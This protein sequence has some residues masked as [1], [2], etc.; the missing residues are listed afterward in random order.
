VPVLYG[1]CDENEVTPFG[2]WAELLSRPFEAIPDDE[3]EAIVDGYGS[4]L[5]R[6]IPELRLRLPTPDSEMHGDPEDERRQLFAAVATLIERLAA[7]R[8]LLLL[9]DDLHWADRSSLLLLRQIAGGESLE[10][11]LIVGTYRDTELPD[12]HPLVELLADLERDR[13]AIRLHLLG[14]GPS[15]LA[16][17]VATW[18]GSELPAKTIEALQRDTGGNPFFITQLVRDL[19]ELPEDFSRVTVPAGLRDVIVKRVAR[20]PAEADRVLKIAALVGREFDLD[21]L[22]AVAGL[23]EEQLLDVLDAAVQAGLL[24]EIEESPGRYSFA[25]ALLRTTL[26]RELTAT[27]SARLHAAIGSA[28]EEAHADDLD[29]HVDE[30]ARHF[31]AAGPGEA[32]R[33]VAYSVRAS[34][35]AAGRLAYDEAASYVATALALRERSPH[36]DWREIA[37]LRLRFGVATSCTGRWEEARTIFAT[38]ADASREADAEYLFARAALGH[39]GGNFERYGLP[40]RASADLLEEALRRLPSEDTPLRAQ[41]LA[42]LGAVLYYLHAPVEAQHALSR[43][44][45]DMARRLDDVESLARALV[46]AQYAYWHPG[47][48]ATR[49]ELAHQLIATSERLGDSYLE[50]GSRIWRAIALLDHC[51]L[52]EAD[53]DLERFGEIATELQRPELLVYAAA[54]RAMRALLEGRWLEG[55]LAAAEVLGLGE[56]TVT[57]NALQSYGVEMMQLRNEQLR[58]GELT[59]HFRRLVDTISALPA[60][61]SA[62][63]WA[64]VQGGRLEQAGNEID[65]LRRDDF[66]LLPR[67]ANL[68]P[69]CAILGHVA[70]ELGDSDLAEAVEPLLRP[71]APY[72]VVMGYGP[73]TLGPVAFT[74]GLACQLTGRLDQAV[75]D[76]ELALALSE[77]MRAR[78]YLAHTRIHL[79]QVLEQRRAP[80]DVVRARG[81]REEGLVTAREL[82]MTRLLRDAGRPVAAVAAPAER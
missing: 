57:P 74:L 34:E 52:D 40:D 50:S 21:L 9:L 61:R 48:Q 1:R 62:L 37:E 14:L 41:V 80:G 7:H 69:A 59:D 72:W 46:A 29:R 78:P 2:L 17:L 44:A 45:L 49:L 18:H 20:L 32:D 3:L 12:S 25:H 19:E 13:P 11:V 68:V 35:I 51:R 38:A 79:A 71:S 77:R 67:D 75:E 36:R 60:W 70:G 42:R 30:L 39:S 22:F 5:A 81:L 15:D 28:I 73:A 56:H 64:L 8:P 23:P 24:L 54:H 53:R 10:R 66:A 31:A 6:L 76:F 58:L 65:L 55:E 82:E 33:A 27:R 26:E 4:S 16:A 63:A 43:Q 47:E